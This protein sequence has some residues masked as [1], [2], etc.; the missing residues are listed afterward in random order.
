VPSRSPFSYAVLRVVPDIEREEFVN[1]GLVLF[2]RP[3]RYL[4]ARGAL[5][6]D[7]LAAIHAGFDAGAIREQLA[8]IERIAAGEVASG[9]LAA[10]SQSE[11]FHWLT[12]PR[13]TAIQPGPIHG[14]MTGDPA[15]T[16]EHLF[17]TLVD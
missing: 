17:A 2:C 4:A 15:A 14:G 5:E 16:F 1:A 9:P 11:R 8:L 3:Q 12:T 10:M 6:T 13:S 7:R